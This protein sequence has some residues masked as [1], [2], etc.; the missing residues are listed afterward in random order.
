MTSQES[1][2]SESQQLEL[3]FDASMMDAE[4][5]AKY[6]STVHNTL[7]A[8]R[9]DRIAKMVPAPLQMFAPSHVRTSDTDQDDETEDDTP[10][11]R[12]KQRRSLRQVVLRRK[13]GKSSY[14]QSLITPEEA[15]PA[16]QAFQQQQQ[17][18]A[19]GARLQSGETVLDESEPEQESSRKPSPRKKAQHGEPGGRKESHSLSGCNRR[20]S[21]RAR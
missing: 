8:S 5:A 14:D 20:K 3:A 19:A 16:S 15:G 18:S 2:L 4:E 9:K 17:S 11:R 6:L 7:R 12:K 10:R 13:Q 1:E 21:L